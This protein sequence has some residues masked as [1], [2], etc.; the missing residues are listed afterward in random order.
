MAE[1]LI[2]ANSIAGRGR[3]REFSQ[4]IAAAFHRRGVTAR[5][6]WERPQEITDDQLR[7]PEPPL[8][9]VAIGGD[10]TLRAAVQ[11]VAEF[12]SA[13]VSQMPPTLVVPLGTANLMA[14][15]LGLAWNP[16]TIGDEVVSA[17]LRRKVR[18]L[19]AAT[20]N[21]QLFLLMAGVGI[22]AAV[23]HELDRIRN[24]P[25]DLTSYA[26][27]ALL[28]LHGYN[29]PPLS[30]AIDGKPVL[31]NQPAMAFIGNIREYGT[32]FPIL[33]MASSFDGLLDVCVL[34]CESRWQ[35]LR[36]LMAAATGDHVHEEGVIYQKAHRIEVSSRQPI[37]VQI[38]GD[39]CGYTP[40]KVE[41]L[42]YSVP[43]IV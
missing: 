16:E 36:L 33:T 26:M 23:V 19:D 3:G 10:G 6:L 1:V 34:P 22:D 40:L 17:V 28:A 9:V 39:A 2:F 35:V 43:F 27:P 7:T 12:N 32:G 8:A 37:P 18:K 14:R 20:A 11:R 41:L 25:I 31:E 38:D 30:V 15:H 5:S 29:Y 42:P 4:R 13:D 21:G 24:G